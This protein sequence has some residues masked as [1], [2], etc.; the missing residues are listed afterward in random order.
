MIHVYAIYKPQPPFDNRLYSRKREAQTFGEPLG[1]FLW[2]FYTVQ[3]HTVVLKIAA[4]HFHA[5]W[6]IHNSY[7]VDVIKKKEEKLWVNKN[8]TFSFSASHYTPS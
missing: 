8:K 2:A 1:I 4:L 7:T 3:V 6:C 5:W